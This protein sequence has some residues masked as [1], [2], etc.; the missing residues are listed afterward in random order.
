MV[1]LFTFY[2]NHE[3][4]R[5][6]ASRS[7]IDKVACFLWFCNGYNIMLQ[8]KVPVGTNRLKSNAI[9]LGSLPYHMAMLIK[10]GKAI[11][12]R[13]MLNLVHN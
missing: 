4:K 2:G 9:L 1:A 5:A 6:R 8:R 12:G 10:E 11:I 7:S 3:H 13:F